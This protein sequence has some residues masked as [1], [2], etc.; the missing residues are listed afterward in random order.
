MLSDVSLSARKVVIPILVDLR[1]R[2]SSNVN[3][4]VLI[5]KQHLFGIHDPLSSWFSFYLADRSQQVKN[6]GFLSDIFPVPS[7]VP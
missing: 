1:I 2:L 5:A 4:T 3:H 6:N 7:G